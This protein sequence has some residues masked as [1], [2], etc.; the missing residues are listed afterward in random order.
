MFLCVLC[1]VL[2]FSP[3]AVGAFDVFPYAVV[4]ATVLFFATYSFTRADDQLKRVALVLLSVCFGVTLADLA[5]RPVLYHLF[6]IRP[7]DRFIYRWPPLP[8]L[9]RYVAGVNF[10]GVT[11]GDLAAVSGQTDWREERRIRFVTDEYGFRNE[12]MVAG[13]EPGPLDV[14]V[15][16]DSFGLAAGTDQEEILSS[17]LARDFSLSVYN[18]SISRENPQQEHSNLLLEGKRLK[19]QKGTCVLW[20]LFPGNDLDEPYY[21]ELE[22]PRPVE[23]GWL[24][25]LVDSFGDFRSRSPVRRLLFPDESERIIE[26]K[27]ID[28]R[29]MLFY[30]AYA[31]RRSR[32]A[33]D[34]MRHANFANMKAA[35]GAMHRL[36]E[37]RGLM[38]AVVV[39]PM[40]EEVYSWG[41]DGAPA[42]SADITQSGFSA[43]LQ[44]LSEQYKF[45]FLDL[46]PVLVEAS[47]H[48]YETSGTLL[49][50][51]DDTHWNGHGQRVAADAIYKTFHSE[52]RTND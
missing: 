39:V 5:A 16:G 45:R 36:A 22:N 9:H 11:Y 46:K 50:W 29:P 31:Q 44:G 52:F 20:L 38:V 17:R 26:R 30:E 23:H 47:R 48:A 51:R 41:L 1:G 14:I 15:L 35:L 43:V 25:K 28:G 12:P 37:E 42:W 19:T 33:E 21:R 13:V 7:A 27:F 8:Q 34:V 18:L 3:V 32:A 24:M 10:E 4:A 40:K 49:Y 2:S 6:E